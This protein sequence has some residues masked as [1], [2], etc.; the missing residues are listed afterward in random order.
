MMLCRFIYVVNFIK[1]RFFFKPNNKKKIKTFC[2]DFTISFTVDARKILFY[3]LFIYVYQ[4]Q[5]KIIFLILIQ[6]DLA[7]FGIIVWHEWK[8]DWNYTPSVYKN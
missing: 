5:M 6:R 4:F 2:I 1:N 3:R 8:S 7:Y